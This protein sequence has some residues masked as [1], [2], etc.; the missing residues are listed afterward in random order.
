[1]AGKFINHRHTDT[2]NAVIEGSKERLK[3]PYYL[4]TDKKATIVTY[5]NT[6]I[7]K[8]TTDEDSKLMYSYTNGDTPLKF[9]KIENAYLFGIDRMELDLQLEEYGVESS[10]IEGEAYVLPDTFTPYPQDYFTINHVDDVRM[11]FKVISVSMDTFQDGANFWK[12]GY[13]LSLADADNDRLEDQVVDNY[14]MITNTV[15]TNLKCIIRKS[16]YN[17]IETLESYL[18]DLKTY[19]QNLFFKNRLQTFIYEYKENFFYDPYLIEFMKR[20][21]I[22]SGADKYVYV[23]H[24]T[25]LPQTFSIDYANTF[26]YSLETRGEKYGIKVPPA[27]GIEITDKAT[28]FY[29]RPDPYYQITYRYVASS[30]YTLETVENEL[31]SMITDKKEYAKDNPLAYNNLIIRY[32][33]NI[34]L[35]DDTIEILQNLALEPNIKMYYA[36]PEIIFV[37]EQYIKTLMKDTK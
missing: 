27:Y 6:N 23:E 34:E 17:L 29:H 15:G 3:N 22:L 1:M 18:T 16:E 5:Y 35:R 9:N 21:S 14:I 8:T 10:P 11:I 25:P 30:A 20:N 19:Y 32:F 24:Q 7:D 12:I 4:F 33:N 26:F 28:L 36:I 31:L 13:R 2:I 37:L